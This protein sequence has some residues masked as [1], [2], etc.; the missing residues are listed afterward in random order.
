MQALKTLIISIV[1]ILVI[2]LIAVSPYI[3][4]GLVLMLLAIGIYLTVRHLTKWRT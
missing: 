2:L 1:L 4:F 3:L